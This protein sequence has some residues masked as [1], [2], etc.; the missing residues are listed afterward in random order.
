MHI[1]L[2]EISFKP[3]SSNLKQRNSQQSF[4]VL[5]FCCCYCLTQISIV[6]PTVSNTSQETLQGFSP[7][8]VNTARPPT[9]Q[10][11]GSVWPFCGPAILSSLWARS[12]ISL[13]CSLTWNGNRVLSTHMH[14]PG[15]TLDS[16]LTQSIYLHPAIT[17]PGHWVPP[18]TRDSSSLWACASLWA[19][20]RWFWASS[21][22]SFSCRVYIEI[23]KTN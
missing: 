10:T 11:S 22:R 13:S 16:S 18:L 3:R 9:W 8:I 1:R 6:L 15:Y 14:T 19:T 23:T 4:V 17:P 2:W 7:G 12:V 20:S 5:T 21:N